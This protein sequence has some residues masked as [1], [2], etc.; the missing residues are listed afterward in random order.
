MSERDGDGGLEWNVMNITGRTHG[1]GTVAMEMEETIRC[2][3]SAV[4]TFSRVCSPV[5]G[6]EVTGE[7]SPS[8]IWLN[9]PPQSYIIRFFFDVLLLLFF[10]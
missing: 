4:G 9:F 6:S 2:V 8:L 1:K 5:G 3:L 7:R 10:F